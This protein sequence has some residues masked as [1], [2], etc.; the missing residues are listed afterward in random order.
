[1]RK[2]TKCIKTSFSQDHCLPFAQD[3]LLIFQT[4]TT[5][6]ASAGNLDL[7]IKAQKGGTGKLMASLV[8]DNMKGFEKSGPVFEKEAKFFE[9][10]VTKTYY[11]LVV[12]M[13]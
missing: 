8:N 1:M 10:I 12:S 13:V 2:Q 7:Y 11:E 9:Q 5:Q 6:L 4:Y 3:Y